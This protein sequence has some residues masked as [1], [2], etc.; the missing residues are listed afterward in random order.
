MFQDFVQLGGIHTQRLV[1]MEWFALPN[2][3][4][5]SKPDDMIQLLQET[6]LGAAV[7]SPPATSPWR[8]NPNRIML[9][10]NPPPP[11]PPS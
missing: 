4:K 3:C 7:R 8:R 5:Y 6:V 2:D 9:W 1:L 10:C 11:P